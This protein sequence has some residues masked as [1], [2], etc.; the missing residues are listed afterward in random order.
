MD[1][2]AGAIVRMEGRRRDGEFLEN[3]FFENGEFAI[4]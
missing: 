2:W 4:T 1:C 3:S